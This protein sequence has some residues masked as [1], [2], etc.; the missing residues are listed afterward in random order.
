MRNFSFILYRILENFGMHAYYHIMYRIFY[1]HVVLDSCDR[2]IGPLFGEKLGLLL[3]E[4]ETF[5]FSG[6]T[7]I[8]L[9]MF[10]I[11]SWAATQETWAGKFIIAKRPLRYSF[12][13]AFF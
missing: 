12:I 7:T 4:G 9:H 8:N 11:L 6:K 5:V 1:L 10:S 13:I 2:V 3:R